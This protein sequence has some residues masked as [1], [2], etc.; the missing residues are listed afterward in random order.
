MPSPALIAASKSTRTDACVLAAW[1][2]RFIQKQLAGLKA[3]GLS[4]E[5]LAR[6]EKL[7]RTGASPASI[8]RLAGAAP[9]VV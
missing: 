3:L 4:Q 6:E 2:E 5:A 1:L 7:L 8:A 9:H